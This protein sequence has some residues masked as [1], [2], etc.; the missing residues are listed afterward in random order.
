[1]RAKRLRFNVKPARRLRRGSY[2]LVLMAT[3]AAGEQTF[4][5]KRLTLR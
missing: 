2:E 1:V 4:L 3:D 5:I